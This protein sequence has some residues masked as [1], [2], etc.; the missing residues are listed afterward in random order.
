MRL[1]YLS[2]LFVF[3]LLSAEQCVAATHIEERESVLASARQAFLRADFSQLEAMSSAYRNDKSRTPS[4]VWKL[5][6]FYISVNGA[7]GAEGLGPEQD[8]A[9]LHAEGVIARWAQQYPSSPTPH[10]VQSI[11]LLHQAWSYRGTQFANAV[12]PKAWAPFHKYLAMA[13]ENLE[14]Y[15]TT[16]AIDPQWY[17]TMLW[18]ANGENWAR[19]PFDS[20]LNEALD[21]EPLYYQTYFA[22]LEYLLPKWHGGLS[23]IDAFAQSAVRRTAKSDGRGVYARIYW[24][25]YL[26][27]YR[28]S[29]FKQTLVVWPTMRAGF[30]DVIAQYPDTWNVNNYAKFACL[31]SDKPKAREL[32]ARIESS[33]FIAEAWTPVALR[34]QC[35]TWA[36]K[37]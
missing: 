4:G 3:G 16:A 9:F 21:R 6:L 30:E 31:A 34:E 22:A 13:R 37:P 11:H 10:I 26:R 32:L 7:M 12:D 8:A 20:M 29:L 35:A 1:L 33:G 25:A 15:K 23:D 2:L 24:H 14:K 17:E 18:I 28:N 27:Q 36:S 5:A 19:A